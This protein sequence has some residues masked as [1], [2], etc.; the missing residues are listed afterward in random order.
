MSNFIDNITIDFY[1][2]D[3]TIFHMTSNDYL[4]DIQFNKSLDN[5]LRAL[6]GKVKANTLLIGLNNISSTFS[7]TNDTSPLYQK[8]GKG[9]K[10][11]LKDGVKVKGTF[12][13]IDYD[14]PEEETKAIIKVVDQ[15]YY[16][17]NQTVRELEISRE[18]SVKDFIKE[19]LISQGIAEEKII[20]DESLTGTLN[21]SI[22]SGQKVS[23]VLNEF[24]LATDTYIYMDANE[25]VVIRS[26][27]ISGSAEET[28]THTENLY[29][30]AIG[31]SYKSSY[32]TLILG[33]G[34]TSISAVNE[35]LK[36]QEEVVSGQEI[37]QL[38]NNIVEKPIY[39]I[40]H[41]KITEEFELIDF[42][43][44][45]KEINISIQN[46]SLEDLPCEIVIHGRN[47]EIVESYVER[48]DIGVSDRNELKLESKLIQDKSTADSV[49]TTL[50]NRMNV[51]IPN[52]QVSIMPNDF[53]IDLCKIIRILTDKI[54]FTGYVHSFEYVI[55]EGE[56][57][58]KIGL[59]EIEEVV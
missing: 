8:I 37:R 1:L 5:D 36:L 28:L 32:N 4:C 56:V 9:T 52:I 45:Q 10:A 35:L 12:Y 24:C 30:L 31:K 17:L 51:V 14:A 49:A 48:Q 11:V 43:C 34:R 47:L 19:V 2:S 58:L 44:S 29:E 53:N 42:N 26:R 39:D 38:N 33:Y 46:T 13:I 6:I 54:D 50:Y 3:S 25:N 22:A 15:L 59:K 27:K 40:D 21:Y 41:F 20:V 23:E 55:S 16:I 57:D 18:K 7:L